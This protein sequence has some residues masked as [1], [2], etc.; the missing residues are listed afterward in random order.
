[1][2]GQVAN[3][4][5]TLS[6]YSIYDIISQYGTDDSKYPSLVKP[7]FEQASQTWENLKENAFCLINK[8]VK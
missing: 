5:S 8:N 2:P 3:K 7:T 6:E 1:M 4:I